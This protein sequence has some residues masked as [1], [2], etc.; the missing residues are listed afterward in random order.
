MLT[1]YNLKWTNLC[2]IFFL[3]I[4]QGRVSK[5]AGIFP[6]LD[7]DVPPKGYKVENLFILSNSHCFVSQLMTIGPRFTGIQISY[8]KKEQDPKST[9]FEISHKQALRSSCELLRLDRLDR[10]A[11]MRYAV[12]S[13]R[14]HCM[15][16]L[17][18]HKDCMQSINCQKHCMPVKSCL[19]HC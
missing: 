7:L 14:K 1:F 17:S 19:R 3:D 5:K 9:R 8:L 2:R 16:A 13:C 6:N 15:P 4:S 12:K 18:S 10:T 11:C